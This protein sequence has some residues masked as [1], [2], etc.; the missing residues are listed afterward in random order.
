MNNKKRFVLIHTYDNLNGDEDII[1]YRDLFV[2]AKFEGAILRNPYATYQFG[3]RNSTMYK[4]K[5][6]LDGK[7]KIIDVIPEGAK[8]PKFSKFVLRN[9][10]NGETFEC[11]PIGDATEDVQGQCRN[12]SVSDY[13]YYSVNASDIIRSLRVTS[14]TN[15]KLEKE[16]EDDTLIVYK[17]LK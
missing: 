16:E 14:D 8:R 9:D 3:K 2:E 6:I 12:V 4:S 7:F 11:M 13:G 1:K 17:L 15:V 10:V 5:P